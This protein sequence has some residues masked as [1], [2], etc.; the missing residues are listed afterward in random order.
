MTTTMNTETT[1]TLT[2][3]EANQAVNDLDSLLLS[4][5]DVSAA[6][7]SLYN[8]GIDEMLLKTIEIANN[9]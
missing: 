3:V 8:G 4:I 5:T 2:N 6:L 9:N 1:I 7:D